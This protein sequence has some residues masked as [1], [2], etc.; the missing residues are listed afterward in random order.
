MDGG[1]TQDYNRRRKIDRKREMMKQ[2][3]ISRLCRLEEERES[4]EGLIL[5]LGCDLMTLG[6]ALLAV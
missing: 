1:V 5:K 4:G 2:A 3:K 6:F